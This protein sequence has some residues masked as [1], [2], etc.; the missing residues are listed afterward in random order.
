MAE[1]AYGVGR[2]TRS[3]VLL[4]IEDGIGGGIVL[5]DELY[6][7]WHGFGHEVGH[8]SIDFNGKLCECG[9]R[10]C[11]E[12]F[13]SVPIILA[14]AQRKDPKVRTWK[15]FID[16]AAARDSFCERLLAEQARALAVAAV[17]VIN[18]LELDGIVLTGDALYR[19]ELLRAKIER[20]IAEH[21]INRGLRH[22]PVYLSTL[23]ERPELMAAAGI[24][25]EKF[26]Q[27]ITTPEI[28]GGQRT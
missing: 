21:T 8:T 6:T 5:Q 24:A 9:L 18:I 16:K 15:A 13:S 4:V 23:G 1:R 20:F 12:L 10:G 27:G 22:V 17:N 28:P 14:A 2:G 19:G 11:V 3:F 26:F 25:T 7:G